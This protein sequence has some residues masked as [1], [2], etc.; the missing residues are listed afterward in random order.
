MLGKVGG[1]GVKNRRV[2]LPKSGG[3]GPAHGPIP[4]H[5]PGFVFIC[6]CVLSLLYLLGFSPNFSY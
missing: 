5:L 6:V 3:G 4:S 1:G 2:V